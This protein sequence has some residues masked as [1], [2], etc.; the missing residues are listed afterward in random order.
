MPQ[1]QTV[2][3]ARS[4]SAVSLFSATFTIPDR[5]LTAVADALESALAAVPEL[6]S[7]I[8]TPAGDPPADPDSAWRAVARRPH[9][10]R[11]RVADPCD[12][13]RIEL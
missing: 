7:R 3:S 6:S 4:A 9:R 8:V 10:E 5:L 11:D 13:R 2:P 1:V 12:G